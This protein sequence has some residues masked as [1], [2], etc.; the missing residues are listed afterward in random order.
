MVSLLL[1]LALASEGDPAPA[2]RGPPGEVLATPASA[3][4]MAVGLGEIEFAGRV[5]AGHVMVEPRVAF[6]SPVGALYSS[7][8]WP[9]DLR[10]SGG[11][12]VRGF[13][14]ADRRWEVGPLVG[15]AWNGGFSVDVDNDGRTS[16]RHVLGLRVGAGVAW[17][18]VRWSSVGVDLIGV[19]LAVALTPDLVVGEDNASAW[20]DFAPRPSV[21]SY[22]GFSVRWILWLGTKQA[23]VD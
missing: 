9:L 22:V 3:F 21:G 23:H 13:P 2:R 16:H 6:G 18:P 8:S 5:R 17:R 14:V 7:P 4:V 12:D 15:L 10:L 1:G 19:P 11:V 20:E